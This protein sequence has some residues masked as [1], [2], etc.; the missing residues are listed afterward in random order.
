MPPKQTEKYHVCRGEFFNSHACLRQLTQPSRTMR[1]ML[2]VSTILVS[3]FVQASS[4]QADPAATT[5]IPRIVV[6]LPDGIAPETVMIRYLF[7]APDG[8]GAGAAVKTQEGVRQYVISTAVEGHAAVRAKLV[9]YAPGCQTMRWELQMN[10]QDA[11]EQFVC[12]ALQTTSIRGFLA[13]SDI[14][15][16]LVPERDVKLDIFGE[17]EADWICNFFMQV[18][19]ATPKGVGGGSCMVPSIRLGRVGILD[20]ADNGFFEFTIPD[21]THDPAYE[22]GLLDSV[23]AFGW[24]EI[25]LRDRTTGRPL[26]SIVP[27]DDNERGLEIKRQYGDPLVFTIRHPSGQ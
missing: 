23:K 18:N 12:D 10:S 19:S 5:T 8:R 11:S 15:A 22:A 17:L 6:T 1:P 2:I 26:A 7:F 9:A 3:A 21:F 20:P 13:P 27:S 24:L 14:P 25:L 4:A 16:S